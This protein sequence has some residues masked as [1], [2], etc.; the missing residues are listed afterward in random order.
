MMGRGRSFLSLLRW[1][2]PWTD[3][4][5]SPPG[6]EREHWTVRAGEV[7][8]HRAH[9]LGHIPNASQP[10]RLD[11]YVYS[12]HRPPVGVYLVAPGLHFLGPDDPRFDRFCRVL[13]RAGFIV[14]A[15]F[16]ASYVNL[17]INATAIDDLE[18]LLIATHMRWPELGRPAI[19]S[20]SFGSWPA[21]EVAARQ[22]DRVDGVI[23]FGGYADFEALA[24]FCIDGVMRDED[25]THTLPFDPL[26]RPALF[27]NLLDHL[28]LD[29]GREVL[30]RA[31]TELCYRTW[32]NMELK[33]PG[34]LDPFIDEIAET[35]PARHRDLFRAGASASPASRDV[36]EAAFSRGRRSFASLSPEAAI[37]KITCPVIV[38]HGR[39]DDVIPWGEAKKLRRLLGDRP[40]RLLV[41][42]LYAHTGA[43][44]I[45]PA[46]AL[47]EA[48]TLIA[49][50]R[51]MANGGRLRAVVTT[52]G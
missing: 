17:Q 4:A 18:E 36:F 41:T 1:L 2:G 49:M 32:G 15:P 42:G 14:V 11:A 45:T 38:C 27:L 19:F 50:A 34:R 33:A 7:Q 52:G 5:A 12:A 24:Y 29:G 13:S 21:L 40:S 46:R 51:M 16:L 44:S 30:K 20:I 6:V 8:G 25:G 31:W 47:G 26:N 43:G 3:D 48:A 23:S 37:A 39:E 28:D 10:T 35:L 22:P 9:V